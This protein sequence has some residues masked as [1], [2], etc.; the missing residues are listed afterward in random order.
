MP[1][2]P[3]SSCGGSTGVHSPY[4][5]PQDWNTMNTTATMTTTPHNFN[6]APAYNDV[7]ITVGA[8]HETQSVKARTNPGT[9]DAP[10]PEFYF[11]FGVF[12]QPNQPDIP[13]TPVNAHRTGD[14]F[15]QCEDRIPLNFKYFWIKRLLMAVSTDCHDGHNYH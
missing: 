5:Y 15:Q 10:N 3:G 12:A 9:N 14:A 6:Q 8:S 4:V 13:E 1:T 11:D 7:D 2:Y